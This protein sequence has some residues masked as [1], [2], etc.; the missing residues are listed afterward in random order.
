MKMAKNPKSEGQY[1]TKKL[2]W[3]KLANV[4]KPQ[5]RFWQFTLVFFFFSFIYVWFHYSRLF[6]L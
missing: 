3:M 6:F 2:F 1:G 4:T 5:G